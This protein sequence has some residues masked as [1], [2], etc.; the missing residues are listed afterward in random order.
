MV[1]LFLAETTTKCPLKNGV[2][3]WDVKNVVFLCG[4]GND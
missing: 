4:W 3:L 1:F 2:R